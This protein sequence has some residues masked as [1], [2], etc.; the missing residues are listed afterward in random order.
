MRRQH[1]HSSESR[2]KIEGTCKSSRSSN[3][4]TLKSLTKNWNSYL[5]FWMSDVDGY[6][7]FCY[8]QIR[9]EQQTTKQVFPRKL[10]LM[11]PLF[12]NY[13]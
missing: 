9:A 11:F 2:Q 5:S 10:Q 4:D 7:V 12:L 3:Q 8:I 1:K 13:N 6:D